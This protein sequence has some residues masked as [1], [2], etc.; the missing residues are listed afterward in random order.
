MNINATKIKKYIRR[1]EA[2]VLAILIATTSVSYSVKAA[3]NHTEQEIAIEQEEESEQQNLLTSDN[4]KI[5]DIESEE[6][7]EV[8]EE[9]KETETEEDSQNEDG[10][11]VSEQEN[12]DEEEALEEGELEEVSEKENET[13]APSIKY[14]LQTD[15]E[16]FN[17]KLEAYEGVFPE[18]EELSL[19]AT[20]ITDQDM[21]DEIDSQLSDICEE[22]FKQ[23][24]F[25]IKVLNAVGDEL[26]PD[27]S[28]YI[29]NEDIIP[30]QL[31]IEF[32][33]DDIEV[34]EEMEVFHF[35]DDL[36]S[37]ECL[38]SAVDGDEITVEPEHFSVF[39]ILTTESSNYSAY[40]LTPPTGYR[41][42]LE[43]MPNSTAGLR[44]LQ[45]IYVYANAGE[46]ISFGTSSFTNLP[47]S[48]VTTSLKDS[49]GYSVGSAPSDASIAVTLP[50]DSSS[51]QENTSANY[52]KIYTSSTNPENVISQIQSN[53]ESNKIYLFQKEA[54]P[55]VNTSDLTKAHVKGTIYNWQQEALGPKTSAIPDG[56]VPI[57]FTAPVSGVYTFRFFGTEYKGGVAATKVL[58]TADFLQASKSYV[59][60]WDITVTASPTATTPI[61]GRTFTDALIWTVGANMASESVLKETVYALTSDGFEYKVDF[62]GIDPFGF[63][64]FTNKRGLLVSSDD[65]EDG[66][67]R[68]LARSVRSTTNTL[69]DLIDM[70]VH[71]NSTPTTD[72][73]ESYFITFE[74]ADAALLN[75]YTG[76][77]TLSDNSSIGTNTA[78]YSPLIFKGLNGGADHEGI[79]GYG[80]YFSFTY[81]KSQE[82][83]GKITPST[84]E[85][86]LDFTNNA[87][88]EAEY[89]YAHGK[90]NEV[91]LSN[92]L[93]DGVNR[94]FWNG[95]DEYGNIVIGEGSS[96][97]DYNVVSFNVKAG[98]VHF[99][100]LDVE[101]NRNGIK[102]EMQNGITMP[103]K[104]MIYYDNS[105]SDIYGINIGDK[106]EALSG[107]SS[108]SGA[109]IFTGDRGDRCAIDIWTDY[110]V[111]QPVTN[112]TFKILG[113]SNDNAFFEAKTSWDYFYDTLDDKKF[114][115]ASGTLPDTAEVKLQYRIVDET[116]TEIGGINVHDSSW[117][118]SDYGL[119]KAWQDYAGPVTVSLQKDIST[120]NV[121]N[122]T[123]DPTAS[124]A[125]DKESDVGT[126][127]SIKI[128]SYH[129]EENIDPVTKIHYP[130]E[131]SEGLCVFSGLP[132][133]PKSGGSYDTTK[134]YQYRVVD[135]SS[136]SPGFSYDIADLFDKVAAIEIPVG[137]SHV[138][139]DI[140]LEETLDYRYKDAEAFNL[141]FDQRWD[142][143]LV[144][145]L[146]VNKHKPEAVRVAVLYG[147]PRYEDTDTSS[148]IDI[149]TEKGYD[150]T[151]IE[152]VWRKIQQIEYLTLDENGATC[153]DSDGVSR[154]LSD[155]SA[156]DGSYAA[157]FPVWKSMSN[158]DSYFYK[159]RPISYLKED[160]TFTDIEYLDEHEN[161]P[162][163]SLPEFY[164]EGDNA[165][166]DSLKKYNVIFYK[167]ADDGTTL[168]TKAVKFTDVPEKAELEITKTDTSNNP[169]IGKSASYEIKNNL[170]KNLMFTLDSEGQYSYEG[171]EGSAGIPSTATSIIK[172]ST[173][174]SIVHADGLPLH[175]YSISEVAAPE[176]YQLDSSSIDVMMSEFLFT[177]STPGGFKVYSAKKSQQDKKTPPPSSG[178]SDSSA[179]TDDIFGT[180]AK[181]VLNKNKDITN[182][183][184]PKTGGLTGSLAA[185]FVALLM[186]GYGIYLIKPSKKRKNNGN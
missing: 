138:T 38:E 63:V 61:T 154:K 4:T 155:V 84:Y 36:S 47:K 51:M 167:S 79:E 7:E 180:L 17:I 153:T 146:W 43:W 5:D 92:T 37:M 85:I 48:N 181:K 88:L 75:H 56:Y 34:S 142:D 186:I 19:F 168:Y 135:I 13:E 172:T 106:T 32:A 165:D 105:D 72:K 62:N 170:G 137:G 20:R 2:M 73:D 141:E 21:L 156:S 136:R 111:A 122:I 182:G 160:G 151:D 126:Y 178:S 45:K 183:K 144:D 66:H 39:T 64:F 95:K 112:Y 18:G 147:I 70:G 54:V 35:A 26:Q 44:R 133:H 83:T 12:E 40:S 98:E 10:E 101:N 97:T 103:D 162:K 16:D 93:V 124:S 9:I 127:K 117:K 3:E 100:L 134:F 11:E 42:Y 104:T 31:S 15:V 57:S 80:G 59:G 49:F 121:K 58:K 77:S 184:L 8:P 60:A 89:S 132:L 177:S 148:E 108:S 143:S 50:Y 82:E 81:D 176:G 174:D 76:R 115:D 102:I 55:D 67:Y 90:H 74:K 164:G 27:R 140:Y 150:G 25:D 14:S 46:Q 118:T 1:I 116:T 109:M 159:L 157:Y 179:T 163:L 169:I 78:A 91:I 53:P 30:I 185:L 28:K 22:E 107:V 145:S 110:R 86:I 87:L 29:D 23:V 71:I 24:S 139:K 129:Y 152:V 175:D 130:Y 119:G 114:F 173:I 33:N 65:H 99:P 69:D 96:G 166:D 94:I 123:I 41:T 149:T 125:F 120:A 113:F 68:S 161:V 128:K 52:Y 171:V 6:K 131:E 158:G